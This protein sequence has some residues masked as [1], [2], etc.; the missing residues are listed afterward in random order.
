MFAIHTHTHS[1]IYFIQF[2]H[3][4]MCYFIFSRSITFEVKN[5]MYVHVYMWMVYR[6]AAELFLRFW[7][8]R[9]HITLIFEIMKFS[10]LLVIVWYLFN[11][12]NQI[13]C[14]PRLF[15]SRRILPIPALALSPSSSLLLAVLFASFYCLCLSREQA[16][17]RK[18]YC[19]LNVIL[20]CLWSTNGH[21]FFVTLGNSRALYHDF[22]WL[23]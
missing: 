14:R 5:D 2:G 7:I 18:F 3:S 12:L 11:G 4:F 19:V 22:S 23:Q 9:L 16:F 21:K 8:Q 15:P 10:F 6:I 17:H 20:N 13:F 1:Y